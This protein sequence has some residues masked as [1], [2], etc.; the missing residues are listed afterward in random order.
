MRVAFDIETTSKDPLNAE[1]IEAYFENIDTG[2]CFEYFSKVDKWSHEAEKI[3]GISITDTALYPNK[4]DALKSLYEY[5]CSL[6]GDTDFI[7]FANEKT[8][9]GAM[10]FDCA[11][12]E[13]QLE[14]SGYR[15]RFKNKTSVHTLAKRAY[16]AR[17]FEP[18][19]KVET[20]RISFGQAYVYEAIFGHKPDG[21]HR[22]KSDT[23]ALIKI[24]NYLNDALNNGIPIN[25][26]QLSLL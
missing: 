10:Y 20:N 2:E 15:Y 13:S 25:L 16:K 12:I 21:A 8:E 4:N 22:A 24:Y 19:K 11:V 23:K 6:P 3:H 18:M 26:D 1:I 7:M 17:L 5:L 14:W 9:F